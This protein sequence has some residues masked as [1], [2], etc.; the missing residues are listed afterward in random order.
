MR[1]AVRALT[2]VALLQTV[3]LAPSCASWADDI[4]DHWSMRS[5]PPRM[6]RAATGYDAS[7]E[8]SYRD[9]AWDQKMAIELT[10][11][12]HFWNHNPMNPNQPEVER[13]YGPRPANSLAPNPWNYIH[14]EGFLVGWAITGVPIPIPVDSII[15]T[16][17]PGGVQEFA[18]GFG[19]IGGRDDVAT[20][21][22]YDADGNIEPFR[23]T[24]KAR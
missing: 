20:D 1:K 2:A 17:E 9:Y 16:I 23:M 22:L 11:L 15:G 24:D 4:D 12:R 10:A 13:F 21:G 18:N 8:T 7:N 6:M 3:A 19:N 14:V 5:L